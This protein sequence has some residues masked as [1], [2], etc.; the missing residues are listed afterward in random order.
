MRPR[1][2]H[3]SFSVY[4]DSYGRIGGQILLKNNKKVVAMKRRHEM[5]LKRE[6]HQELLDRE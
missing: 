2:L 6:K 4:Q 5:K 1:L 3:A